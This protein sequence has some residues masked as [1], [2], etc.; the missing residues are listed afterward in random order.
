MAVALLDAYWGLTLPPADLDRITTHRHRHNPPDNVKDRILQVRQA[1]H[2][3]RSL[4]RPDEPDND[5]E[6]DSPPSPRAR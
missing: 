3:W 4:L 5:L 6:P 2:A 1:P